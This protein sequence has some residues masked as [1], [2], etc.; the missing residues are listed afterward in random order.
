VRKKHK[1]YIET[2]RAQYD[3]RIRQKA[4]LWCLMYGH[5]WKEESVSHIGI[6]SFYTDACRHCGRSRVE[7]VT[8]R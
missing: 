8:E 7:V 6:K 2:I 3:R 1:A 5:L 4:E